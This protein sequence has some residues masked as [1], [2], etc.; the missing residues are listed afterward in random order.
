MCT[1]CQLCCRSASDRAAGHPS[2]PRAVPQRGS[3]TTGPNQGGV[4]KDPPQRLASI[5]EEAQSAVARRGEACNTTS[6]DLDIASEA[7]EE[8]AALRDRVSYTLCQSEPERSIR[9]VCDAELVFGRVAGCIG[10]G[11]TWFWTMLS[12]KRLPWSYSQNLAH[13]LFRKQSLNSRR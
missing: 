13:L 4:V 3:N 1:D 9:L 5:D 7:L 2:V 6:G 8:V 11:F 12:V 10:L